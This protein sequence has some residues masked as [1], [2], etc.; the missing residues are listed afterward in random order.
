MMFSGCPSV[1]LSAYILVVKG[2][3]HCDAMY[4]LFLSD[5]I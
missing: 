1:R 5:L 2:Q 4:G 3:G